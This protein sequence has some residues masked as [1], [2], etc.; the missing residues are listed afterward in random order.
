M[1]DPIV[2]LMILGTGIAVLVWSF[3]RMHEA[4]RILRVSL[5]MLDLAKGINDE[6][7]RI[8]DD[9]RRCLDDADNAG[10]KET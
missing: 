1:C 4:N 9:S 3:Y 7:F 10:I 6:S 5:E 2:P 8:N